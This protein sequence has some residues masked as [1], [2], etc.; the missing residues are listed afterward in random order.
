MLRKVFVECEKKSL[1][2]GIRQVCVKMHGCSDLEHEGLSAKA[3]MQYLHL[4]ERK[5]FCVLRLQ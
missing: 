1:P 3:F 4:I 5:T 2:H